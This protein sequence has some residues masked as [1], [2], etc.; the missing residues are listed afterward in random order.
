[1]QK[2]VGISNVASQVFNLTAT[3]GTIVTLN[4]SYRPQQVG[5]FI[6]LTWSGTNPS[7]VNNGIRLTNFPNMLRQWRNIYTFGL[8]CITQ[9]GYDPLGQNDFQSGYAT[10]LFL[11]PAD[12]QQIES[13]VFT[14]RP[15]LIT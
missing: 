10:L 12:V 4:I 2:V 5:W 15:S 13:T 9:D 14:G 11:D 8:G 6:D 1:M 3:D 7:T